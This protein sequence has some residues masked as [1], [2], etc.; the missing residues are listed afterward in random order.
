MALWI[1]RERLP[2]SPGLLA[3]A[4]RAQAMDCILSGGDDYVLAFTLPETALAGLDAPGVR[5]IGRVT[6]GHGVHLLDGQGQEVT[7]LRRGYVHF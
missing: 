6:G 3:V 5:V 7:P 1:D 4:G 2:L